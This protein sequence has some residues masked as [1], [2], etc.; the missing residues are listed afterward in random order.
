MK[1]V[2]KESDGREKVKDAVIAAAV[3][4]HSV[5][6]AHGEQNPAPQQLDTDSDGDGL[7][8]DVVPRRDSTLGSFLICCISCKI[9]SCSSVVFTTNTFFMV[10]GSFGLYPLLG[11]AAALAA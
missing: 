9:F 5:D 6:D 1:Y 8:A 3:K 10:S 2:A 4:L 7:A 11:L